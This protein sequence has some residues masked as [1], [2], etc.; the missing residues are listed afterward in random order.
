MFARRCLLLLLVC[1]FGAFQSRA[2]TGLEGAV[3]DSPGV[4]I[5][6]DEAWRYQ[7][8]A[9][10]PVAGWET[11]EFD[12]DG[13]SLGAAA[14]SAGYAG[15]QQG[16]TVLPMAVGGVPVRGL[17]A[18]HTFVVP[19]PAAVRSLTLRVEYEDGLL[20]WLNGDEVARLGFAPG[21]RPAWNAIPASHP[22]GEASL[23]DLTP[24]IPRLRPGTNLLSL[25]VVD[26]S[27]FGPTLFLWPELRANFTRGPIVQNVSTNAATILWRCPEAVPARVEYRLAEG[28]G[29]WRTVVPG[30]VGATQA[31]VLPGLAEGT[32]YTYRV[33]LEAGGRGWA[34][35][36]STFR[37]LRSSGDLDFLVVGDTG[38]STAGHYAV[39][40]A[41]EREAEAAD[42]LLH[43]GDIVYPGFTVGRVDLRCFGIHE[44]TLSRLPWFFTF[45]N[46]DVYQGEEGYLDS[47]VLPRNSE[48]GGAQ[49]YSFD[50]GDVHFASLFVPWWGLSRIGEVGPD[51]SRSP[52]YRWLTNDLA[53]TGKRWKVV[54]FHQ[55]LR[56]SGP[57]MTDDY[58]ADG[59]RDVPQ[60]QE[61]L[62]PLLAA[63]GVDLVLNGHD[64]DWERFAPTAGLHCVVTGGGGAYL[65]GEY[66]R[67]PASARF[68]SRN[69]HTRVRVRHPEM[70][71][72][73]VSPEGVV[74]DRFTI[75]KPGPVE[76]GPVPWR[77]VVTAEPGPDN[78]DGNRVGEVFDLEGRGWGTASAG[79][80]NLGRVLAAADDEGVQLG[81]RDMML[82]PGQT[83]AVF[84]GVGGVPGLLDPSATAPHPLSALRIRFQAGFASAVALLGDEFGDGNLPDL[85]RPGARLPL[86]QGVYRLDEGLPPVPGARLR[87]FN[88]S[89]EGIGDPQEQNANFARITLPW[90]SL[91]GLLPGGTLRLAVV[92]LSPG[93]VPADAAFRVGESHYARE[94]ARDPNGMAWVQPVVLHLPEE[95]SGDGD[96]DGL[97]L[98]EELA[99]GTDPRNPDTDGDGLPDGWEVRHGLGPTS[100]TGVDGADGDPDGD[101]YSNL[102]EY[103]SGLDPRDATRKL[104]LSASVDTSDGRRRARLG[105]RAVVGRSYQLE[106]APGPG[107]PFA[108][109]AQEGF[110]RRAVAPEESV[111]LPVEGTLGWYRLVE[112]P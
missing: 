26:A 63:L 10:P 49:F 45:G 77:E 56:T 44:R 40:R 1:G 17:V 15:Y 51:G 108:P 96:L 92:V 87:Q 79:S 61:H 29:P 75:R 62:L 85:I 91:A 103:R 53:S 60:M 86:G 2:A 70:E 20:V 112:S 58:N 7:V 55:P 30:S 76:G 12:D 69:H 33:V 42:L 35:S 38:A 25:Q 36:P 97:S 50:H 83:V 107:T 111:L 28:E 46:H 82:W 88:Q 39:A 99:L 18:R 19:E 66:L 110:P 47:F 90:Q 23:I 41:L 3:Q 67:D 13:W 95:P 31:V 109:S 74:F 21:D 71:I 73:A 37:T 106:F 54:F 65:Y 100:A 101:G 6:A 11:L 102:E 57:H 78:L 64:H 89:P 105:W 80:A 68:I 27:G 48:T 94:L 52:Q 14:F 9:A 98:Q 43:T 72:E 8:L 59:L 5:R 34:S 81:L 16:A 22:S 4:L 84:L 104:Q 24:W 93:A 32:R